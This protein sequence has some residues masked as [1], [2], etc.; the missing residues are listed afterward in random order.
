MNIH[1]LGGTTIGV[2]AVKERLMQLKISGHHIEITEALREFINKKFNKLMSHSDSIT[3]AQ[4]TL[5][6]EKTRQMAE[7]NIHIK[8]AD[9]VASSE[10]QDMYAAVDLLV[11]KMDRQLLKHK[12]KSLNR[13]AGI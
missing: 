12:E 8:G 4:V 1:K 2:T 5:T 10:H 7:A 6:V 9:I 13:S 11:D 3:N